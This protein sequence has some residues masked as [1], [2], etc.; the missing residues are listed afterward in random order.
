[1]L[2]GL[3]EVAVSKRQ[4]EVVEEIERFTNRYDCGD[5]RFIV[6]S[7]HTS[8]IY[9]T[10]GRARYEKYYLQGL[11]SDR[12]RAMV[13]SYYQGWAENGTKGQG[14]PA[15]SL[16]KQLSADAGLEELS[17]NAFLLSQI[18]YLHHRGES[19]PTKRHKLFDKCVEGLVVRKDRPTREQKEQRMD[20]LGELAL[21]MRQKQK[22]FVSRNE[23]IEMLT[24]VYQ[25]NAGSYALSTTPDALFEQIVTKWAIMR[26]DQNG[27]TFVHLSLHQYLVSR[28][29]A[30][31]HDRYWELLS[32]KLFDLSW[33]E[34]VY[35]Y[36]A[37]RA[38][39]V[40][41][42][43]VVDG[44]LDALLNRSAMPSDELW[45]R[46][47][48]FMS[49][50]PYQRQGKWHEKVLEHL[51]MISNSDDLRGIEA[52]ETLCL[53][54][55]N[56]VKWVIQ[57]HL[58]NQYNTLR[59]RVLLKIQKIRNPEAI[60]KLRAEITKQLSDGV[61]L[62]EQEVLEDILRHMKKDWQ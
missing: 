23:A 6:T 37:I 15:A 12:K 14:E 16:K 40:S 38:E 56:G 28:A 45:I 36:I 4:A 22:S 57:E 43:I 32:Q 59:E 33:Q 54:E 5:N 61:L 26:A 18:I 31:N 39:I 29:I 17:N 35:L 11:S 7:R 24:T 41:G 27:Y 19:L 9:D 51:Q 52:L 42:S 60:L 21:A 20:A 47:G 25:Q 44:V 2:D 10:L 55:P 13:D 30:R 58:I 62:M 1:M 3:D 8:D 49:A 48:F 50:I 34:I 46:A 53:I